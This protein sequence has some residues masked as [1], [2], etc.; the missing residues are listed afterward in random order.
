MSNVKKI[1]NEEALDYCTR[2][3]DDFFDR[4]SARLAG[5]KLQEIAVA[6]ANAEGG[7]IIVGIEDEKTGGEPL[8]RWVGLDNIEGYNQIVQNLVDLNPGVDF[9]HA[10]LYKEDYVNKYILKIDI[11]K[12]LR[13]HETLKKEIYLRK[14]AQSLKISGTKVQ[15]LMRGKGMT[16]EEDVLLHQIEPEVIVDSEYLQN[17]LQILP[18]TDKEP[19]GFLLQERLLSLNPFVPTVAGVILFAP[20][21]SVL[22]TTQC[23]VKIVRYDSSE[24]EID[25]DKLTNDIHSIEG[26]LF[27]LIIDSFEKLKEVLK[28]SEVWTID[29]LSHNEYPEEALWEVLVNSVIHRDYAVS[30]NVLISIYRNRV[31][32]RSPGR[33]PG[34][35]TTENILTNRFSRNA[36]LVRLLSR[37]PNKPNKDLGEGVNTVFDKMRAA[38]FTNPTISDKDN[39]VTVTLRRTPARDHGTFIREFIGSHGSINNRQ[40]LDLLGL[41]SAEHVTA[42]FGKLREKGEIKRHDESQ[43]GIRVRWILP[44]PQLVS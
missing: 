44:E 20:N 33:L 18:I 7:T 9:T 36:K 19:M 38:G 5:S 31:E 24:E 15:D 12:S 39:S 17:Y 21:P 3:E 35:V 27:K 29:G 2:M 41:D 1:S 34:Y 25:R 30:D 37:Y 13:L 26:P 10:F 40:A 16:S 11:P 14:G 4:K 42:L 6:F 32:F 22:L 8:K 43:T 23:A 28:R